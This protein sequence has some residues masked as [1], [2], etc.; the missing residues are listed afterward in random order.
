[1]ELSDGQMPVTQLHDLLTKQSPTEVSVVKIR[2]RKRTFRYA[3]TLL[4]ML[5][6]SACS[7]NS[8]GTPE[9]EQATASQKQ[10]IGAGE[11]NGSVWKAYETRGQSESTCLSVEYNTERSAPACGLEYWAGNPMNV[12][13]QRF[14]KGDIVA[15]GVV[16]ATIGNVT[17][18]RKG[19]NVSNE[20]T[21][22]SPNSNK[23]YAVVFG[24]VDS[25]IE[26]VSCRSTGGSEC[27]LGSKF[28][29]FNSTTD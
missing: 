3:V 13:I 1:M 2:T 9:R 15:Y 5:I 27:N 10:E 4:F 26:N 8:P 12:A 25:E 7:T 11:W 16:D 6:C 22:K 20:R 24:G 21:I 14:K 18:V 29:D 17:V 28:A 19:G 23:S